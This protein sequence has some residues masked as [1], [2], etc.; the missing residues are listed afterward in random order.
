MLKRFLAIAAVAMLALV[1]LAACGDDDDDAA[2]DET[3]IP[4]VANAPDYGSPVAAE[5][6]T[7]PPDGEEEPPPPPP[8]GEL[9]VVAGKPS[10]LRFDPAELTIPAGTDVPV[11]VANE[12][13][14]EH[15]FTVDALGVDVVLAAGASGEAT[16]NGAAGTYEF[17]CKIPGHREGG[18]VG[19][20]TVE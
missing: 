19:T 8:D 1:V 12:G 17:Y 4:N 5:D 3:R 16:L 18:M 15:T 7:P 14:L 10:E 20:L 2:E 9:A 6:G 11:A 13:A